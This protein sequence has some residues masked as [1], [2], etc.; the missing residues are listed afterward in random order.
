MRVYRL[1][2]RSRPSDD[3]AGLGQCGSAPDAPSRAVSRLPRL[4]PFQSA[5]ESVS[6][7]TH[8]PVTPLQLEQAIGP[9]V[10]EVLS[11]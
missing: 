10:L 5:E 7:V 8:K 9:D 6:G 2:E 4:R 1:R 11:K 3:A